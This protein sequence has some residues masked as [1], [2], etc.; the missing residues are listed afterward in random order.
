MAKQPNK[1]ELTIQEETHET[2]IVNV[3]FDGKKRIGDIE[4]IAE[5][6]FQV[7]LADGTSFNARSYEDGLNELIMQYHL[8]K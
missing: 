4:E 2:N 8:H 5:H 3:V 1:V 7:K 6:Q